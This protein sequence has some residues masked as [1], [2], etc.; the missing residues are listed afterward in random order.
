VP[1]FRQSCRGGRLRPTGTALIG[2]EIFAKFIKYPKKQC[3]VLSIPGAEA[4]LLGERKSANGNVSLAPFSPQQ[5]KSTLK[6]I[7]DSILLQ[8]N[9]TVSPQS[10][11]EFTQVVF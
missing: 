11:T 3:L 10:D 1:E 9:Y 8:W 6:I 4:L 7:A 5:L 2:S